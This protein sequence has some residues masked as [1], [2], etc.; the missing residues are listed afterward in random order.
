MQHFVDV[1]DGK[2]GIALLN[3]CLT[4]YELRDDKN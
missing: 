4:E 3:N 2:K 1:S